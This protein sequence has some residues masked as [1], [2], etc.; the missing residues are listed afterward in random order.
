MVALSLYKS[1]Q[2]GYEGRFS[3][4]LHNDDIQDH[5]I[6]VTVGLFFFSLSLEKEGCDLAYHRSLKRADGQ[7][8]NTWRQNRTVRNNQQKENRFPTCHFL[9]GYRADAYVPS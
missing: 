1:A 8:H 6:V 7:V 4:V 3:M 2:G 5:V 9:W